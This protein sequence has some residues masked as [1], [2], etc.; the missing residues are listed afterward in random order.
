MIEKRKSKIKLFKAFCKGLYDRAY[1]LFYKGVWFVAGDTE[2]VYNDLQGNKVEYGQS[3]APNTGFDGANYSNNSLGKKPNP[4]GFFNEKTC[5]HCGLDYGSCGNCMK[6]DLIKG[7]RAG[8]VGQKETQKANSQGTKK[9]VSRNFTQIYTS[10][11]KKYI[12]YNDELYHVSTVKGW[13][14]TYME[15]GRQAS[16]KGKTEQAERNYNKAMLFASLV[17]KAK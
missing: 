9:D 5:G 8:V 4:I 13:F 3:N 2:Y 12:A 7:T 15:R 6:S 17:K 1:H 10:N 16:I 14:H 11:T